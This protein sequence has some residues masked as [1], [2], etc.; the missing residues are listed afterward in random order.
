MN[1]LI[2]LKQ[3][4]SCFAVS[5]YEWE[6]SLP[7]VIQELIGKNGERIG[8]NLVYKIGNKGKKIMISAHMDEVGFFISRIT[9][10]GFQIVPIGEIDIDA[11]IGKQLT[12]FINGKEKTTQKIEKA[13]SY[14][15][16][17]VRGIENP[18]VGSIGTFTKSFSQNNNIVTAPS[19]DNKVGCLVLIELIRI[20]FATQ[21]ELDTTFYFCFSCREEVSTNG[22][23]T[24]VRQINPDICIDIDS[25]YAQ[26]VNDPSIKN[27]SIPKLGKGAA[28]QLMGD[29]FIIS[30]KNRR[31]VED[32]CKNFNISFQYE[33][34]DSNNGGTNASTLI[35]AGYDVIQLNIPVAIQHTSESIVDINDIQ[36][37]IKIIEKI[38]F[39][40]E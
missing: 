9:S 36:Q 39:Q 16:L 29:G 10:D 17:I 27:W 35:N 3:L 40:Y 19:L 15:S 34:P 25:A 7:L 20:M 31:F 23:M 30:A 33:I 37:T 28:I 24:A 4:V 32:L 8:D 21:T 1:L 18:L 5:G 26:P 22:L 12:F 38:L 11:I 14:S 6:N 2:E 13:D